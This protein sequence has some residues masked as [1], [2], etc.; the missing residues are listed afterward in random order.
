MVFSE[1][2]VT[3]LPFLIFSGPITDRLGESIHRLVLLSFHL[4]LPLAFI[5]GIVRWVLR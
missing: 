3:S 1:G 4:F 2:M 5:E